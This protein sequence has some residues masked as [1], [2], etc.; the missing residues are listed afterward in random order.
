MVKQ[1]RDDELVS[2]IEQ[3]ESTAINWADGELATQRAEALRRFNREPYGNEVEGRSQV[4]ANDIAD[5]IAVHSW[6]CSQHK[7]KE[8]LGVAQ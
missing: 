3:E 8:R 2:A 1:W 4:V 5:A 6:A 7:L